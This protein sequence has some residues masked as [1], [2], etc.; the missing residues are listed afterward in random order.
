MNNAFSHILHQ[1]LS[2]GSSAN[3][4]L[5]ELTSGNYQRAISLSENLIYSNKAS[6]WALKAIA[7][8]WLFDY[9]ANLNLLKSSIQSIENFRKSTRLSAADVLTIQ[10]IFINC[11]LERTNFLVKER[12]NE[13]EQL[14]TSAS[15]ERMKGTIASIAAA[16]SYIAGS[17]AETKTGKYL[18]YGGAIAGVIA[19]HHFKSNAQLITNSAKGVFAETVANIAMTV[20][21]AILLKDNIANID[22][23]AK[24]ESKLIV[25]EY[26][27][28][29]ATIYQR[30]IINYGT[31]C[32]TI[33]LSNPFTR[34][35]Y[36]NAINIGGSTEGSQFLYF[37]KTLKISK[38][39][40]QY[41]HI[42]NQIT[43]LS[44]TDLEEVKKDVFKMHMIA[45][46]TLLAGVIIY[47]MT[48][49]AGYQTNPGTVVSGIG[50]LAYLYFRF[51][52][53]GKVKQL[54]TSVTN[55]SRSVQNF[56]VVFHGMVK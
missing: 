6:G 17:N 27:S 26:I 55:F 50:L 9:K 34:Y 35:F 53:V 31:Y 49:D 7:Q 29:V 36:I 41:T 39:V 22:P 3:L 28:T 25:Q 52:P 10:A 44:R 48:K 20:E 54:K 51:F 40:P 30:V 38:S 14:K 18:G 56:K 19:S 4:C 12:L 47:F 21:F 2:S 37:S 45:G 24:N 1:K 8:S 42:H 23:S 13:I 32:N 5:V 16:V 33:R 46:G 15:R 43:A 11:L